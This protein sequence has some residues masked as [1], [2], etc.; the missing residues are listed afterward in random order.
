MCH[1][2]FSSNQLAMHLYHVCDK[3]KT[4]SCQTQSEHLLSVIPLSISIKVSGASKW[5]QGP[6]LSCEVKCEVTNQCHFSPFSLYRLMLDH[7]PLNTV[8]K[9]KLMLVY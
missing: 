6:G 1:A 3:V 9:G 7:P 2:Q 4:K 8:W 5:E